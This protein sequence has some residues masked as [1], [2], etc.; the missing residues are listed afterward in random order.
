MSKIIEGDNEK[1]PDPDL[2]TQRNSIH[3]GHDRKPVPGAAQPLG[4]ATWTV[5][6]DSIRPTT[7]RRGG[8]RAF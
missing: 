2:H 6:K 8:S 7:G 3:G 1:P 4:V 5:R